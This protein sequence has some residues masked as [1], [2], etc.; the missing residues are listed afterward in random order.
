[1]ATRAQVN[2]LLDQGHSYETAGRTLGIPP[3]QAFMIVTGLPADGSDAPAPEDLASRRALPGSS[4]HLVNPPAMN[5]TRKASVM[6][7]VQG[8][9]ARDLKGGS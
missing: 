4:Q 5:P 6:A 1:M 8:R 9:A 2:A 7:W 3:G